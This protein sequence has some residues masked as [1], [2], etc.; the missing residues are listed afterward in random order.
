MKT[1][2]DWLKVA[3]RSESD[4]MDFV[5]S[6]IQNHKESVGYKRAKIGEEYFAGQN[7]TIK[8]YEKILY[9]AKG[10]AVPD[11][12][13]ANHRISTRFFFR[14]VTQ[15]NAVLL[16]NGISWKVGKGGKSLGEDFDRVII[17]AGRVAQC[18]GVSFGFYNNGSVDVFKL[19]EFVP[20]FDEEDGALK[21]GIRFWQIM[22]DKPL[23]ATLFELDGYTEYIWIKG[24]GSVKQEKRS[25]IVSKKVSVADGEEIY[26]FKNYPSFPI[27]P[28]Y[29]NQLKES[30]L[31]PIRATID[32][33]DLIQSGYANDIDDANIIYWTISNAGGMDDGDL[34]KM[35]DKL[36]KLHAAQVDDDQTLTPHEVE[37][38]YNGREAILE[39]LEKTLYKDAMALNTYDIASGAVTATQIQAAYDPLMEKLDIYEAQISDFIKG[40]LEIAGIEDEPTYTRSIAVNKGEEIQAILAGALYLDDDYITEKIMT[41][42]GDKDKIRMVQDKQAEIDLK[43]LSGGNGNTE[44]IE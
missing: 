24:Q 37:A 30:E 25:Y 18:E 39:R 33:Y 28:C 41:I 2:Q 17:E 8:R 26:D 29:A 35:I 16:G 6:A 21:A 36:K 9:N 3:E 40:L 44:I 22:D 20:L 27:V 32:A 42:L 38:P 23:R 14:D 11:Y 1:Y 34:V 10:Q 19:T 31:T 7:T 15:A 5:R 4:R 43:R 12:V 13:S